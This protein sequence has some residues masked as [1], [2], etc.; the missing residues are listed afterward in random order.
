MDDF[1]ENIPD[2]AERALSERQIEGPF[3]RRGMHD[4]RTSRERAPPDQRIARRRV[5][6]EP[7][8]IIISRRT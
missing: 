6:G 7:T 5:P 4:K 3:G 1:I 8:P 2:S